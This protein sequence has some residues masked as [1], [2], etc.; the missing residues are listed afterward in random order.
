MKRI[1]HITVSLLIAAFFGHHALS[2]VVP[3]EGAVEGPITAVTLNGADLTLTVM[4]MTINVPAGVPITSSSTTL[5]PERLADPTPLPGRTQP[6]FVGGTAIVTGTADEAGVITAADVFVEPAENVLTGVVTA[7]VNGAIEINRV[8]ISL[9]NDPRMPSFPL[10]NA[11]GFAID[12]ATV[13]AG[14]AGSAE[15]YFAAGVFHAF[16]VEVDGPTQVLDPNPQVSVLRAQCRERT[17]NTQRGDE[18]EVR[19]GVTT[20]HVAPT[21]T[22]QTI[23]V[24]RVDN[25]IA[26]LLG[27]TTATLDPLNP[28]F[29][30]WRFRATTPPSADPVLGACPTLVR[31]V[32]VSPG[33]NNA[34]AEATPVIIP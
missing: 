11:F 17:P 34:T 29:A 33:A 21:V 32:N 31:A 13:T 1:V 27:T 12:P 10:R 26:T 20:A 19:G 15:G 24:F 2:Q 6:G 9:D 7:S 30:E 28:G 16:L 25:G 5:T 18:V 4:G 22:T 14:N 23:Q 8:P 3:I